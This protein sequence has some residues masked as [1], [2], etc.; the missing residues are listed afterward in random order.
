[1]KIL[2]T[3]VDGITVKLTATSKVLM[4]V[5]KLWKRNA[6]AALK[7]EGHLATGSLFQ[8]MHPKLSLDKKG[9]PQVNL[10]PDVDYW[11]FVDL[12]VKGAGG[13]ARKTTSKYDK[14]NNKGKMWKQKAPNS[15][16]AY[17]SK[18]PPLTSILDWMKTKNVKPRSKGTG[19]FAKGTHKGL[20]FGIQE[21]IF[22]QGLKPS[23]FITA[24]QKRI[25]KKYAVPIAL[26]YTKD[27]A[28]AIA[29]SIED[30]YNN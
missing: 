29:K 10:T 9:N 20:A 22:K 4:R 28:I 14:K 11:E 8:S 6:K 26:A 21:S 25:E 15:P 12:G 1:M 3:K 13:A 24:T 17:S 16:F 5:G 27:L 7:K 19:K 30:G 2:T 18:R 23:Y